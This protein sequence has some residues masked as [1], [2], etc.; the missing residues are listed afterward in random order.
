[1]KDFEELKSLYINGYKKDVEQRLIKFI[2][3]NYNL[4][5]MYAKPDLV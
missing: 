2:S 1:M 3:H 4:L 5:P